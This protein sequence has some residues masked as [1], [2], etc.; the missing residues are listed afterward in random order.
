[1]ALPAN[2][3]I[4]KN[5]LDAKYPWL[6]LLK[7]AIDEGGPGELIFRFVRNYPDV[8]FQGNVY[9]GFNFDLGIISSSIDGKIRETTLSIS[10]VTYLLQADLEELD[11]AVDAVITVI[12]VHVDNLDEDYS[13]LEL[14]YDVLSTHIGP[15]SIDFSIGAPSPLLQR[16]LTQIY[17]ADMCPYDEF[18]G[19][20]CGYVGAETVCYRRLVDCRALGNSARFGGC[21]GLR[22]DGV[23]FL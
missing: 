3:I 20:R 23:R 19:P 7:F 21:P 4:E 15:L 6:I 18:K 1:M 8:T 16:F 22:K 9:T 11:G 2:L 10:N 12:L 13:E 5:K 17:F 14:I